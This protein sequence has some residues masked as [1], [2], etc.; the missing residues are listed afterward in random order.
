MQE[1]I[2][3]QRIE[4]AIEFLRDRFHDQPDLATVARHVHLSE[5]HLQRLFSRWAGISPKRFVQCLT[6]EHAK[7]RLAESRPVLDAAFDAGLS[8]PGRLHDLFVTLEAVT[9]GEFKSR[10]P[11]LEIRY[12]FHPTPFGQCLLA[13]TDRGICALQ[14]VDD[15]AAVVREL[16]QMWSG[17]RCV[18]RAD[19][20]A[21]IVERIF[22]RLNG[23]ARAP[24]NL[25]VT[26]TNF[27]VKVWQALLRIPAGAVASY[28]EVGQWLGKPNAARA[29]GNA[30][31]R[32]PIAYLIPCHRVIRKTGVIGDY[33]WGTTRK[34]ALLAWETSASHR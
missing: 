10:G 19:V 22:S 20:T 23:H 1:V 12:G 28:D 11:G 9:P 5:F 4:R 18:E 33:R 24:L 27:Q 31:A 14:F 17:A 2:D 8:G 34:R 32:N 15:C 26:G 7:Q 13:T 30:V 29:V 6:V 16:K 3:Y 25:L 21:P